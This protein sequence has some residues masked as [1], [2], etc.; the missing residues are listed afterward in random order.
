MGPSHVPKNNP[1]VYLSEQVLSQA[2]RRGTS[3]ETRGKAY[4]HG[5]FTTQRHSKFQTHKHFQMAYNNFHLQR[6]P[7]K[8][9]TKSCDCIFELKTRWTS[10]RGLTSRQLQR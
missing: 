1:V 4:K 7:S 2:L 9:K 3:M 8:T 5:P 10:R 6:K